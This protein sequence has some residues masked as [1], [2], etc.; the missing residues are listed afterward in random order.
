ME[1]DNRQFVLA[2]MWLVP[3]ADVLA[4]GSMRCDESMWAGRHNHDGLSGGCAEELEV[5]STQIC[6]GE[7]IDDQYALLI[8]SY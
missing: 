4:M 2:G 8:I 5:V 1:E 6:M 3:V 7:E